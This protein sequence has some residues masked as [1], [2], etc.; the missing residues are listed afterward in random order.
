MNG[1]LLS[2]PG[3]PVIYYGD[4][5]GMGDNIY[6]A[7]TATAC[8]RRCSGRPTATAASS[9]ADP[10]SARAAADQDPIYGFQ[11]VNVEA[12]ARDPHSLL[13]WMRRMLAVRKRSTRVRPRHACVALSGQPQ[14]AGLSCASIRGRTTR[15]CACSISRAPPQ[16]VELDLSRCAGRVPVEIV[17]GSAFPPIGQLPYL[18][19]LPPYGF[20]W[21]VLATE[22]RS[23][24]PGTAP[25]PEPLPDYAPWSF[26]RRRWKNC[27]AGPSAA[28]SS[29][30]CCRHTCRSA[31]GSRP[32]ARSCVGVRL[33]YARAAARQ[34]R[35]R[36]CWPRSRPSCRAAPNAT[37]CRWAGVEETRPS[38]PL[39]A[40]ACAGAA[41]ARAA[42]RL[43]DRCVRRRRAPPR[44]CIAGCATSWSLP[45]DGRRDAV[46]RR[47]RCM[48]DLELA[49]GRR[50]SAAS[51]PSSRNSS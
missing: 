22:A 23:C 6:P 31:A 27:C 36:S 40:A 46:P 29:A 4:E 44:R 50:K 37:C 32:R 25:A 15:S 11:A 20:Y 21:F 45:I 14:G 9:R 34:R 5:I 7:A 39:A 48:A 12:Q 17:G 47:R 26:A 38:A 3:T 28:I 43:P 42:G 24:R 10:A 8:A 13:N 35:A 16:A 49:A 18:L 41:A 1:L 33:A 2:M 30:R 51:R 19:T